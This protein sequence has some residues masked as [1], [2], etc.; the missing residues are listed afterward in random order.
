MGL[1]ILGRGV[2]PETS[3]L[4]IALD[5]ELIDKIADLNHYSYVVFGWD[6]NGECTHFGF[7]TQSGQI[8]GKNDTKK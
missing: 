2:D 4:C 3:V 1:L 6:E 7:S 8:P 5:A